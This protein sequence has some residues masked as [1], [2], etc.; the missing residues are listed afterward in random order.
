MAHFKLWAIYTSFGNLEQWTREMGAKIEAYV[1]NEEHDLEIEYFNNDDPRNQQHG[2]NR[3]PA[4]VAVKYDQPFQ[5]KYGKRE[6]PYYQ[7][8]VK[9]L[10][11]KIEE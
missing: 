11:W 3:F 2:I 1:D 9:G 10:N 7:E 6:W 4:F 5:K 8:W